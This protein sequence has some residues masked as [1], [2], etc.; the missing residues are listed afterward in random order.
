[1][2]PVDPVVRWRRARWIRRGAGLLGIGVAVWAAWTW[3]PSLLE[4]EPSV[5]TLEVPSA[6]GPVVRRFGDPSSNRER[7]PVD[8]GA[9]LDP[10]VVPSL[11]ALRARGAWCGDPVPRLDVDGRLAEAAVAQAEWLAESGVRAHV[12][13]ASPVGRTARIRAE[14]FGFD[15]AVGEV[16]AWGRADGVDAVAWWEASETH[17]PVVLEP[18]WTHMGAGWS[19]D[20]WVVLFGRI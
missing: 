7:A 19:D 12:T 6:R 20:V 14:R 8:T 18:R 4:R 5:R 10:E 13:P 16:I 15:G 3:G 9:P 11:D 2:S 17:C 1:M